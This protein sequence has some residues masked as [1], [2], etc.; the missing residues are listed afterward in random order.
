MVLRYVLDEHF[1]RRLWK[2]LQKHNLAGI[3]PVDVVR[4]GDLPGIPF[5]INDPS[6][7][8]WAELEQRVL[9]TRDENTRTPGRPLEGRPPFARS[10]HG[11]SQKPLWPSGCL[12]N[13]SCLCEPTWDVGRP[14]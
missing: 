11:S 5:G 14:N 2:A 7:L 12:P 10:V 9:I 6:L 13:P 1:R 3:D 4:V 8:L